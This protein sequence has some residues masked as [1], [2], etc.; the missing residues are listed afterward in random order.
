MEKI[1]LPIEITSCDT[2]LITSTFENS[3]EHI[4]DVDDITFAFKDGLIVASVR[5]FAITQEKGKKQESVE[6]A[7]IKLY[8]DED[9]TVQLPTYM[10]KYL[11]SVVE[12]YVKKH[13][14]INE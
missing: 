8:D 2:A 13:I 3:N 10:V 4:F 7:I 5:Y 14:E 11:E 9:F 12:I 6:V 1:R